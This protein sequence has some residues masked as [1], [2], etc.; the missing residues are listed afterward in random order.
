MRGHQVL[1]R[2]CVLAASV[3][4][5]LDLAPQDDG[6]D[7][8]GSPVVRVTWDQVAEAVAGADPLGDVARRRLGR[9]LRL[10]RMAA[11][12]GPLAAPLL[13]RAARLMALPADHA[14]H[15]GPEWVH[16]RV[17]GGLLQLGI[18]LTGMDRDT[19][20]TVAL[21]PGVAAAAGVD[22][23]RWWPSLREHA[24][25]MGSLMAS[26]LRRDRDAQTVLRP[27]GGCDVPALLAS[28]TLRE[29]LAGADGTGM[30]A[31]AVPTLTRGWFDLRR[32]D[33]AFTGAAWSATEP[34]DR[35]LPRALLVTA[36]EVGLAG[37]PEDGPSRYAAG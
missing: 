23:D 11:D 20:R 1:L 32:I 10:R 33:P 15:P 16:E 2:Q 19:D 24:D 8:L 13:A 14:Q 36:D 25:R 9:W 27:V 30:R 4:G 22:V 21:P 34:D 31:V 35:G 7:L 5:D 28:R 12:H 6:V 18:G 3:L 26:R 29:Y 37:S 17:A